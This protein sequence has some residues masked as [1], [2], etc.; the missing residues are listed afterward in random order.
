MYITKNNI[1]CLVCTDS[2]YEVKKK[3]EEK[4]NKHIRER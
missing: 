1:I 3:E 2:P 4:Q